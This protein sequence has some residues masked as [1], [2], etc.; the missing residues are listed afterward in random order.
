MTATWQ[1]ETF[2]LGW[3]LVD[4]GDVERGT[5]RRPMNRIRRAEATV[6]GRPYFL[7]GR[8][9]FTKEL[10]VL[11]GGGV[12]LA[13]MRLASITWGGPCIL[14]SGA[15]FQVSRSLGLNGSSFTVASPTDRILQMRT[16]SRRA[17]LTMDP[18]VPRIAP[19]LLPLM[20]FLMEHHRHQTSD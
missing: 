14:A 10:L 9:G 3:R 16:R 12:V 13:E 6:E 15:H 2:G 11:D 1:R 20:L 17:E 18:K 8:R 5:Y 4:G 19:E 7:E